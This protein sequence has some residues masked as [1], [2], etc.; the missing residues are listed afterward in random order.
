MHRCE[1]VWTILATY[2]QQGRY[3]F[4]FFRDTFFHNASDVAD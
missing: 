2:V 4:Q 3:A 1:R